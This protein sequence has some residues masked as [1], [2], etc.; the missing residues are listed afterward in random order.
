VITSTANSRVRLLR[1][2]ADRRGR[3]RSGLFLVEGLRLAEEAL[4]AG[5]RP[6]LAIYDA[7]TL[8]DSPSAHAIL[9]GLEEACDWME[10]ASSHV[11]S[12]VSDVQHGQGLVLAVPLPSAPPPEQRRR[13]GALQDVTLILDQ[14]SDPGNAG[15]ILRVARAGGVREVSISAGAVDVFAP[16]VVRAAA[17]A[18]FWL[19]LRTGFSWGSSQDLLRHLEHIVLADAHGGLP[20]WELDWTGAVGLIVAAE[21]RG[22]SEAAKRAVT[23]RVRI[24]MPGGGESLNVAMATS[25][26]LFEAVRQ[27]TLLG[28]RR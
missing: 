2:L 20:F 7:T 12:S 19:Y 8:P 21:A 1:S 26:L 17:G 25:V 3:M 15:T 5:I 4:A 16:K 22:A 9:S 11:L 10:P 18:H 6:T 13:P 23:E 14:V 27:R 28:A 24:P